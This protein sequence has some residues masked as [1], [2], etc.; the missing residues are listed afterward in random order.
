MGKH[1]RIVT[2]FHQIRTII[3]ISS[4]IVKCMLYIKK[5]NT[6]S[7]SITIINQEMRLY[8]MKTVNRATNSYNCSHY[9]YQQTLQN[10]P[11][12]PIS[13][14]MFML[15]IVINR[16]EHVYATVIVKHN[17]M[18]LCKHNIVINIML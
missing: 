8:S 15:S 11:Y 17:C 4:Q 9:H 14:T 7:V 5:T 1:F 18:L 2:C 10:S 16:A 12:R 13:Q 3:Y 6:N